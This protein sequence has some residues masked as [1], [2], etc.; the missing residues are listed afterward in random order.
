VTALELLYRRHAPDVYRYAY[1]LLRN[2]ADA[3][4]ALQT[5]FPNAQRAFAK[6]VR[7]R[8]ARPWLIRIARNVC[9]EGFR[10]AGRRP[11]E[12]LLRDGLPAAE[13]DGPSAEE[14]RQA[15]SQL[16]P[17]Q[18]AVLVMRELEGRMYPE[19]A[20][21]LGVSTSAVETLL[22]RARRAMREQLEADLDCA[23]AQERAR[24]GAA[25]GALRAHLRACSDC[26]RA[27]R[28]QRALRGA[29]RASLGLPLPG[30]LT[31]LF[32]GGAAVGIGVATKA[33]AVTAV[34]LLIAGGSY[35]A[36]R[37]VRSA[38]SPATAQEHAAPARAVSRSIAS[39]R[40]KERDDGNPEQAQRSPGLADLERRQAGGKEKGEGRGPE[41]KPAEAKDPGE[42]GRSLGRG[43]R[44]AAVLEKAKTLGRSHGLKT[45]EP[46][47]GVLAA[48]AELAHSR[49]RH[50]TPARACSAGALARREKAHGQAGLC[51]RPGALR[52]E[53]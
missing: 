39:T 31:S 21:S 34:G 46:H 9:R 27:A 19:I 43:R 7:P 47:R 45:A 11:T 49:H 12:V 18:R 42:H 38:V 10:R 25:D 8:D 22:F 24:S 6:G 16:S 5:T 32:G 1:G 52:P 23:E 26:A 2:R 33:A 51:A 13:P 48:G 3:E 28:R 4:D 53:R 44:S 20:A 30:W 35:E 41:R 14:I 37:S 36:S 50:V 17:N 40:G 15:L 29:A